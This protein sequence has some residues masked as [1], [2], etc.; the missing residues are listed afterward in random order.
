MTTIQDQEDS[1]AAVNAEDK[2]NV[3]RNWLGLMNGTLQASFEK[4]GNSQLRELNPDR[5]YIATDGKQLVLPGCSL[6]LNRN[7]GH[8]MTTDTVTDGNGEEIFEGILDAVVSTAGA[9]ANRRLSGRQQNSRHGSIYI[10]KPK[11]HGPEEVA[12]ADKLFSRVE[13][14]FGL[15]ANTIKISSSVSRF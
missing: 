1:V 8:L 4:N 15:A 2:V 3:Y 12:F 14:M 13:A 9:L 5:K 7:V 10:V 6:L 11:M